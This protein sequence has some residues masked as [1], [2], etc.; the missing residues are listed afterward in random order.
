M[1]WQAVAAVGLGLVCYALVDILIWQRIFEASGLYRF[2][3]EY[4][5]GY[6]ALLGGMVVLGMVLL[7]PH[8]LWALW[9]GLAFLTL[10][11]SGLEDA[12]YYVL[13]GRSIPASL[14]WLEADPLI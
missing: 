5:A 2:D 6:L 7:L 14:P 4:H 3:H 12:L 11:F 9:Y 10:A 1:R 13:D 8:G